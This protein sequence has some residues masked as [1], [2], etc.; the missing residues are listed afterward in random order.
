MPRHRT[1]PVFALALAILTGFAHAQGPSPTKPH[2]SFVAP[3]RPTPP[4][5]RDA[6]WIRNPVD[7][8]VLRGLERASVAPAT[9]ANRR[10]LFRRVALDLTGIPPTPEELRALVADR[11]TR[12][13]HKFVDR[14]LAAPGF[15]ER[16]ARHWLDAARYADSHGYSIDGARTIW[17]YRDWVIRAM[18]S[19]MPFDQFTIEQMAGDMLPNATIDQKIATG[20]H[21]NTMINQEGG[22]DRE[23]FRIESVKDRVSTTATAFLG[24]TLTCAQCHDHKYDPL[25][26]ADFYGFYAFLNNDDEP[27]IIASPNDDQ[28]RAWQK[29]ERQL[30][31]ELD[32][33][34]K[35]KLAK[36][37]IQSRQTAFNKHRKTQPRVDRSM[38]LATRKTPRV[39]HFHEAGDFTRKGK[40]MQPAV[41]A[42]LHDL[43][44]SNRRPNRL[45]L[46]RWLVAKDNPLTAR[47]VVNRIWQ[48]HF[49]RGIV[50]T[51]NDFGKQ[52]DRPSHP[53]LLDWLAT[54]FVR[55]G[56][57]RKHIHRLIVTSRTYQQS[58]H[59]RAE[60]RERDPKNLI[61]ARQSRFRLDAEII[62]DCALSVAGVLS[63][64]M[65]GPGV[66]PPQ[67]GG[68]M[69][70]GQNRRSW[71]PS[72]GEDR[73][74]RGIYTF[75][76][77]STP[78]PALMVFDAPT[79]MESCTRR[80][81]SNT[82]LQALTLLNDV[83]FAELAGL[84]TDRLLRDVPE[85]DVSARLQRGFELCLGRSADATE[86][87]IVQKLLAKHSGEEPRR[88]WLAVARVL[89]NLDEFIT[90]E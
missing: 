88:R 51:E 32:R 47:V 23:E 46:A 69:D 84:L 19:D 20:F 66:F 77:R 24:I 13:Y 49:G 59:V 37:E 44:R 43:P 7:R 75:F 36:S 4:A 85:N 62:R 39:S 9:D 29:R 6:S 10:T 45:D 74:R 3:T 38:V 58:S 67:P 68:V 72:K 2:W 27:N 30:R 53:E 86:L 64:K 11:D 8:F 28:F 83:A 15:G 18:N 33:A 42:V 57:S 54:E 5:V 25:S 70:V 55:S 16:Q 80:L 22:V 65:G 41:P 21:R 87:T 73:Y 35:K 81:R 17:P 31:T 76:W 50:G 34:K 60:L 61:L 12:A 40:V 82:P 78:H 26:Q 79:A 89:L 1:T 52:G 63:R 14:L 90:R 56:W 48:C 71:R